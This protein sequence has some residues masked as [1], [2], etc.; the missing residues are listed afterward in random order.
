MFEN[1]GEMVVLLW[2][3]L[4]S[5]P[6]VF[7]QRFKIYDQLFEIGNASLLMACILSL[8]IGGVLTLQT[9]PYL[10]ERVLAHQ[11]GKTTRT[12]RARTELPNAT[13]VG[14]ALYVASAVGN[15]RADAADRGEGG[16][17]VDLIERYLKTAACLSVGTPHVP[18]RER[19]KGYGPDQ[20]HDDE[21]QM[22]FHGAPSRAR[23]T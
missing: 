15:E 3:T 11:T 6:L 2:R 5:L 7:R 21:A 19:R 14:V 16:V 22:G 12:S 8:F 13:R 20:C 18:D 9:A 1:I 4:R 10:A 23:R 17:P